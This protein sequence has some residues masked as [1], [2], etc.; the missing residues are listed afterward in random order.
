MDN[1][2]HTYRIL[3]KFLA[4]ASAAR[5]YREIYGDVLSGG[6]YNGIINDLQNTLN[7]YL[8]PKYV[9]ENS[10]LLD[11]VDFDTYDADIVDNSNDVGC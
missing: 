5:V 8:Y 1:M 2:E 6:V 7:D 10:N 9:L 11:D 4:I 3:G